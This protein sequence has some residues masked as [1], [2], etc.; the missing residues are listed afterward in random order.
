[1]KDHGALY[2]THRVKIPFWTCKAYAVFHENDSTLRILF[3][4]YHFM[5]LFANAFL[6]INTII[7][8]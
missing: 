4:I 7:Q 8:S 3:S 5:F 6:Y 2:I 1:M